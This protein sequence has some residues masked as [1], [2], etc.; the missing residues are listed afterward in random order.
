[1]AFEEMKQAQ[2]TIW[3][4]GQFELLAAT[5]APVHDDLIERLGV[6][7][8]ED[9]LDVATGTGAVAVRAARRGASVTG[10]DLAPGLIE[11]AARL[12][13]EEGLDIDFEVGDVEQLGYPDESFDVISSAQGAIF[14]PDHAAVA[15]ELTRVCRTGGRVGLTAWRP[16]GSFEKSFAMLGRFMPPPPEGAGSPFDWGRRDY[17]SR[18]LGD[19]FE[20]EF[21]DGV[22][23]QEGESAEQLWEL[24]SVAMGPLQMLLQSGDEQ[25]LR[26]IHDAFIEFYADY[27]LPDGS[28]SQP[29]EYVVIVGQ[30]R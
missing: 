6:R 30:K 22:S 23:P 17:V 9:W 26:E 14:G 4:M 2:A 7:P 18:L 10:Q 8:G 1:M 29:R 20:L 3:G 11:T 28:I 24:F 19:A 21:F 5:L 25:R 12:A 27:T 13:A 15:R 16:G